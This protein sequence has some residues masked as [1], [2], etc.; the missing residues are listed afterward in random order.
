MIQFFQ[1]ANWRLSRL[2]PYGLNFALTSL[3][4]VGLA[5]L[6]R[7]APF[8]GETMLTIDLGQQ[9]IDFFSQFRYTLLHSPEQF[10]YSFAKGYGGEMLGVWAYYLMSPFNLILLFF[11][12]SNL[13][14]AVTLLTYLK[15]VS[16]S[17]TFFY[18]A[19][20]K[21]GVDAVT[22]SLF[23]QA[24]T[25]MSYS[26][27]YMLNIMW[28][29]GLVLLPLI[30]LG[31]DSVI[32][33]RKNGLYIASLALLLIANYYIGYMVCLFLAFYAWYV[34]IEKDPQAKLKTIIARYAYFVGQSL[35]AALISSIMLIPTF[36][37]LLNNKATHTAT[38]W[39]W[40]TAH[41]LVA[42]GSK[43][44]IGSFVFDEIKKGSPN[45]YATIFVSLFVVLYFVRRSIH[46]KEKLSTFI[47][48]IPFFLAF[49]FKT[50]DR[51]WHGGQFPIWYHFRFSFITVFFFIILALKA[52]QQRQASMHYRQTVL[53]IIGVTGYTFFYYWAN[54]ATEMPY[55]F[56]NHTVNLLGVTI[57]LN[58]L[59]TLGFALITILLVHFESIQPRLMRGALLT[60]IC[61]E[62]ATNAVLIINE[63]T[64]VR[65]SKFD[66]YVAILDQSLTGL[67]HD[68][69]DFYRIH[70]TYQRSKNEA[71]YTHFD[72]MNHFG[73]TIEA[74]APILF[75]LLGLPETSGVVDYTNGTLFTDDFFDIR[76]LLDPSQDTAAN[77]SESQYKLFQIATDLDIQAHPI[78]DVQPR[79]V[80][81]ENKERLGLGMEVSP[82]L[83]QNS[84]PFI[85][86]QSI[87]NQEYLLR[88]IDFNG[89]GEPYFTERTIREAA[90][91]GVSIA[92]RGDGDYLTYIQDS[93]A[94]E[95]TIANSPK[96]VAP[97]YFEF[98]FDTTSNNPYYFT[99]PSQYDGEKVSMN[100][101]NEPYRFYGT[102]HYRQITNAAY[103]KIQ[104]NQLLQIHL[105]KQTLQANLVKLYEFDE[106]RYNEM[107]HQKQAH[108][109]QVTSFNH[110]HITGTIDTEQDQGYVLFTIPY[111]KNWTITDNGQPVTP[112]AVLNDTLMAIPVT[113]GSHQL[114]L[115]YFPKALWI[116]IGTSLLGLVLCGVQAFWLNKRRVAKE[117]VASPTEKTD[118]PQI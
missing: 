98:G 114:T 18:F 47:V 13:A 91:Q 16:A 28:F 118:T 22:G 57:P 74:N 35:L 20:K 30:A 66:D 44:F 102:F 92:T 19:R 42:V 1:P 84:H 112:V 53:L 99:I 15:L 90:T 8:G 110:T 87:A 76:Y 69:N 88:L 25:F 104:D 64:Y 40:D 29:D 48:L 75:G 10:F 33:K 36:S 116:G 52:Y 27:V 79:Y 4:C 106:A 113:K 46:W 38:E 72:G 56:L 78:I 62:L 81:H 85:K 89:T 51:I 55:K 59:L 9:Y 61:C 67:R 43:L 94:T 101:N 71:M 80:V 12:E 86:H 41:D 65:L 105:K 21:Y 26:I 32:T 2:K 17:M 96:T 97:H 54:L 6:F 24:Y 82:E 14:V 73:S 115:H 83:M 60:V 3:I 7:F 107:I 108:R 37:S 95:G 103:K 49:Y 68:A 93:S 5:L 117:G 11:D 70:T 63:F 77:T 50:F 100:L 45:L 109:F 39:N 34:I 23:S 58:F 31:L 111:D